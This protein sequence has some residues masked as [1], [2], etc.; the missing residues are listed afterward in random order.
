MQPLPT[1][2]DSDFQFQHSWWDSDYLPALL[3]SCFGGFTWGLIALFA[4]ST[5]DLDQ[6]WYDNRPAYLL[7]LRIPLFWPVWGTVQVEDAL[8]MLGWNICDGILM[9]S[10]MVT[11]L[12]LL[13]LSAL[14][15]WL[16]NRRQS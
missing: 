4:S 14:W 2:P 8:G 3:L 16:S 5:W 7:P 9:V 13:S 1:R 11:I 6:S 15:V 10:L 12:P